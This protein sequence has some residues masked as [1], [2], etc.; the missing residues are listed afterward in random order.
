MT[1]LSIN[2]LKKYHFYLQDIWHWSF[3][4]SQ[5]DKKRIYPPNG[6]PFI[7]NQGIINSIKNIDDLFDV[8]LKD[9]EIIISKKYLNID[10]NE[11]DRKMGCWIILSALVNVCPEAAESLPHLY[12]QFESWSPY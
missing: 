9:L 4:A 3:Q 7:T 5:N 2:N 1:S 8:I 11:E 10:R 6:T 12:Q